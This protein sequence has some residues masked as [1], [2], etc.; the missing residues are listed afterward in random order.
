MS[1]GSS[2]SREDHLHRGN[3]SKASGT[4][5][6][7]KFGQ[8]FRLQTI[9]ALPHRGL[10]ETE[11]FVQHFQLHLA[12]T[13]LECEPDVAG[14]LFQVSHELPHLEVVEVIHQGCHQGIEPIMRHGVL[15][16]GV[17]RCQVGQWG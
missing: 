14:C 10:A 8:Q 17:A 11:D 12:P 16:L 2:W 6:T 7:E 4:I 5:V 1:V 9:S 13:L 15:G 3:P